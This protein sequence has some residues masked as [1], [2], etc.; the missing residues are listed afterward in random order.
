MQAKTIYFFKNGKFAGGESHSVKGHPYSIYTSSVEI[1]SE[2]FNAEATLVKEH[3]HYFSKELLD[4]LVKERDIK[5]LNS[6]MK[7]G[8][9][10][11]SHK[12]DTDKI[13]GFIQPM[14]IGEE[15]IIFYFY[16]K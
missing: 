12:W 11:V 7:N 4:K 16:A 10:Y 8:Q 9:Y 2:K 15:V 3:F 13:Y 6:I 14:N 5:T 1:Y